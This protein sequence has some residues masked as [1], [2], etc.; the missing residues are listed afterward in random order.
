MAQILP[1]RALHYNAGAVGDLGKVVTQPYDKITPAMQDR[2]Y[3]VS[4]HNLVRVILGKSESDD[5]DAEN[6]YSRAAASL[7]QWQAEGV[8]EQD[9]E[10]SIYV[11]SQTFKVPGDPSG[12]EAERQGPGAWSGPSCQ[13]LKAGVSWKRF[14]RSTVF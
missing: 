6:V 1:F 9:A 4:P 8:L 10:P 12:A 7:K 11:Y 14:A 3:E 5:N 2:Y 13:R